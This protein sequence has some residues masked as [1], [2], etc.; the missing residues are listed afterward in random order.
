LVVE[1]GDDLGGILD[2]LGGHLY[3][4]WVSSP[5][6]GIFQAGIASVAATVLI[7]I[8]DILNLPFFYSLYL[9]WGGLRLVLF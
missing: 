6:D 1:V 2:V 4:V 3:W 7:G 9:N 8:D 5:F